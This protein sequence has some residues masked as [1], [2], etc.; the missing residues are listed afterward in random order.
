MIACRQCSVYSYGFAAVAWE[1]NRCLNLMMDDCT[2]VRMLGQHI[3]F[4]YVL[5]F[6]VNSLGRR[7]ITRLLVT[8]E[9]VSWLQDT[10]WTYH[11]VHAFVFGGALGVELAFFRAS[12]F[13]STCN[14]LHHFPRAVQKRCVRV[15]ISLDFAMFSSIRK[16]RCKTH[17]WKHNIWGVEPLWCCVILRLNSFCSSSLLLCTQLVVEILFARQL[18]AVTFHIIFV[19]DLWKC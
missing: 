11:V 19:T 15:Q 14:C 3:I 8:S 18:V 9:N 7:A 13:R 6:A 17:R 12:L 5:K 16:V 4:S 1:C 10:C 2:H